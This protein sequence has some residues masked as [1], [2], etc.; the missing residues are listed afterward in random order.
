MAGTQPHHDGSALYVEGTTPV[1]GERSRLRLRVPRAWGRASRVWV[2]SVQDAEPRYD[3]AVCLDGPGASGASG[4]WSWWEASI[5]V[6][7]PVAR[8]RFVIE[9]EGQNDGGAAVGPAAVGR[10]AVGPAKYWFL[11]NEGLFDRDTSDYHDFRLTTG[12]PAPQWSR[13]AVMY[14]V[15]PDRF[16]RSAAADGR[17]VPDWAVACAWDDPV[18]GTGPDAAR[19]F[20]GGDLVGV[21]EKIDHLAGLGVDILYLTPF[22]PARSN[23][24]YDAATFAHVD[25]LLGGDQALIDLVEAA[26][27]RGMKVMGDLTANHTGDAHEW[28]Q[29][30]LSDPRCP[31][32]DYYYFNADH[33]D[34]ECWWGVKSLP[35]LNWAS[36]GLREAFVTGEDSV[37]AHWLKAPF[38]LDGWRIDVGNMAGR[39]GAQDLNKDVAAL[40]Q[41]R[42]QEINPDALLLGEET[43]DAGADVDGFGW[44]GAM[45]YSNFTRPMWQWLANPHARVD[46]FGTPLPCPNKV[47][48]ETVLATHRDLTS[49]F[50]WPVRNAT[51]NALNTHDTARAAT[52]MVPDGPIVA[53]TLSMTLPGIPVVFAGDEFGLEGDRGES[54]RTP[55]PWNE[56]ARIVTDLGAS[57]SAL[58]ALRHSHPAVQHGGL[59]WLMADG[60]VLAFVRESPSASLLVVAVRADVQGLS[61]ESLGLDAA[62]R[63]AVRASAPVFHTGGYLVY[64]DVNLNGPGA[65]IWTLP[66]VQSP[67]RE[68]PDTRQ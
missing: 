24:R 57:Y 2:R 6:A 32:A 1:L 7:N 21:L 28:F 60:D 54:A 65:Y 68:R 8:Y 13:D 23:H 39:L 62:E 46:F 42:I 44:Q 30:A 64:S 15:F 51:M 37:V 61:F 22:F 4:A 10:A 50:S 40:I 12:V 47:G 3:A 31:E 38:N 18:Q 52:V 49:A 55:M 66:G 9:T 19:Q 27:S 48:A 36:P 58:A 29:R 67:P 17:V 20:Y 14:Q 5:L 35:K 63:E 43:S 11:N 53:A 59:R 41:H 33:S 45:T 56:P 26:H 25:P 34:Y 16:A